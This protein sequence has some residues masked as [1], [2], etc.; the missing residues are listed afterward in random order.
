[1]RVKKDVTSNGVVLG[2]VDVPITEARGLFSA[3]GQADN[4]NRTCPYTP[5]PDDDPGNTWCGCVGGCFPYRIRS[6]RPF[7]RASLAIGCTDHS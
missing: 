7:T 5:Q 4:S 2:D 6:G 1:M 3:G